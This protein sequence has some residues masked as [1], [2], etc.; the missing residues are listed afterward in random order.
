MHRREACPAGQLR[1][2]ADPGQRPAGRVSHASHS[3]SLNDIS[4][5][6]QTFWLIYIVCILSCQVYSTDFFLNSSMG[7]DNV[8]HLMNV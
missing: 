4:D 8:A 1:H 2:A 6:I 3:V 5:I 7:L